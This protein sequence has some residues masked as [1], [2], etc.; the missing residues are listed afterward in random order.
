MN[1]ASNINKKRGVSPVVATILL[2][3][4]VVVIGLIVF[5]WFRGVTKEAITKFGTNIELVCN[6]VEF[7]ASYSGGVLSVVNRGNIPI[8]KM[9]LKISEYG[10]YETKDIEELSEKWPQAGLNQGKTF[11]DRIDI[12]EG[13]SEEIKIVPVLIGDSGSGQKTFVCDEKR[14]GYELTI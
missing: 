12:G 11:S 2:V 10:S 6:D 8:F 5:L 1:K 3:S 13:T 7:D 14:Y 9:K 4:I